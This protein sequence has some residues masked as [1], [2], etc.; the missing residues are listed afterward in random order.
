MYKSPI[1]GQLAKV[2][3]YYPVSSGVDGSLDHLKEKMN[4]GYSLVVFPEGR[5]MFSNKLGRFHKGAFFLAEEL[6]L[7]VLPLY[8]HGNS[9]VLPKGDFIIYD[10]NLTVK[11]GERIAIDNP[12]LGN[13]IKEKTKNISKILVK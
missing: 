8:I 10:G 2:A 5:R 13:S 9:E 1:F 3:G 7:D 6:N 4:Q 12:V 11:V